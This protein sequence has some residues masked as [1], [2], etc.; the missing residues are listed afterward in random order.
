[1]ATVF[2]LTV[3]SGVIVGVT[4]AVITKWIEALVAKAPDGRQITPGRFL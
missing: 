1:M 3:L 2:W 4:V